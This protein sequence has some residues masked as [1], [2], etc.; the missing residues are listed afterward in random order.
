[1]IIKVAV[2]T[3][4]KVAPGQVIPEEQLLFSEELAARDH[5]TAIL[6]SGAKHADK[7]TEMAVKNTFRVIARD[8]G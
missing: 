6:L 5:S 7:I 2:T 1:M 3:T 4:L 8:I